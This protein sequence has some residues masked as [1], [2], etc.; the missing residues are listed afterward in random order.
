[1]SDGIH[2]DISNRDMAF[3]G[4]STVEI[5]LNLDPDLLRYWGSLDLMA[6]GRTV[7]GIG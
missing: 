4:R 7:C 3:V 6:H 5:G 1:M 2:Y